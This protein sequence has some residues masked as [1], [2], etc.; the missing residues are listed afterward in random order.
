MSDTF[1]KKEENQESFIQQIILLS[2]NYLPCF[3]LGTE[4]SKVKAVVS[5]PE[6][7]HLLDTCSCLIKPP[8]LTLDRNTNHEIPEVIPPTL[9][10]IC[11]PIEFY[12]VASMTG[13][14]ILLLKL[15]GGQP[16]T[17]SKEGKP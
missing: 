10:P 4:D 5:T 3:R 9:K 11:T 12:Q 6:Q 7:L 1:L 8:T 14:D 17:G 16:G 15:M 13:K 2:T